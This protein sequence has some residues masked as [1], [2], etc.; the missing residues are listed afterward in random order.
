[1]IGRL[2]TLGVTNIGELILLDVNSLGSE[3][4]ALQISPSQ[5][6][7]WQAEARLLS[8]VPDLTGPEARLL[9]AIGIQNPV[10][11]GAE[12][13]EALV[14]RIERARQR[15]SESWQPWMAGHRPINS[16]TGFATDE[17]R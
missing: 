11:L 17:G 13:A 6:R 2:G 8:S 14:R 16:G 15:G 12:D 5:L 9:A 3:L 1:M 4:E 7:L 10:E